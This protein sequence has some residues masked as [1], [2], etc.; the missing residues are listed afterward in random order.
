MCGAT[1]GQKAIG[2]QQNQLFSTLQNQLSTVF[3]NSS[4][5]FNDLVKTY[6]PIFA[7]G[8]SQMGFSTQELASLK[9]QAIS[10]TGDAY[11]H[12][13]QAVG[14]RIASSGGGNEFL[15]AGA[16]IGPQVQLAQGA[17]NQT[18]GELNQINQA[19]WATGRQN[20]LASAQGLAGATNV[21]NPA[22]GFANAST[23]AGQA[24]ANTQNQ[25]AQ[26]NNSW[27]SGALGAL[28]SIGGAAAGALIPSLG[29][30]GSGPS[31][32]YTPDVNSSFTDSGH[33]IEDMPTGESGSNS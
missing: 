5:V 2:D 10:D 11:N 6:S 32:Y 4:S 14:D 13:K 33:L 15:P 9:S 12:A 22:V 19:N 8:P 1:S 29:G 17:A 21:F 16:Q 26:E 20:W 28:G 3:G 25:I 7:A 23:N 31:P 24:A 18:A 27:V 30:S